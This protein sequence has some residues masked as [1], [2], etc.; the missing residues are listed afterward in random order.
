MI[1]FDGVCTY[2]NEGESN[3]PSL[4]WM[5]DFWKSWLWWFFFFWKDDDG[6]FLKMNEAWANAPSL[7]H[8]S[9]SPKKNLIWSIFENNDISDHFLKI[10]ELDT[11]ECLNLTQKKKGNFFLNVN[12]P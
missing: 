3:A 8:K 11:L 9:M 6:D 12:Q 4:K 1:G 5:H 10:G 7:E 2:L